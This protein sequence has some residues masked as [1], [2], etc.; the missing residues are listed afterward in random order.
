MKAML[1]WRWQSWKS[2][3]PANRELDD[4]MERLLRGR[5]GFLLRSHNINKFI[6]RASDDTD[7]PLHKLLGSRKGTCVQPA[8]LFQSHAGGEKLPLTSPSQAS[9]QSAPKLMRFAGELKRL[10][11]IQPS[12]PSTD[13]A[14]LPKPKL[15]GDH[16]HQHH[17]IH[18]K[19]S[20]PDAGMCTP[21]SSDQPSLEAKDSSTST[22][23]KHEH[24]MLG[25]PSHVD[26]AV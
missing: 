17:L 10:P 5:G 18:P 15:E 14:A 1:R 20:N 16:H 26:I 11:K 9:L 21:T 6:R 13:L 3:F 19:L 2:S 25:D 12:P 24:L 4:L 8:T 23:S 22:S 7:N